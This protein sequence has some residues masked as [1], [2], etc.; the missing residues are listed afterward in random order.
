MLAVMDDQS[1]VCMALVME[2]CDQ[3]AL[4]SAVVKGCFLQ[5]PAAY[6]SSNSSSGSG[7][8]PVRNMHFI[9]LTLVE[10]ALA[11]RYLHDHNIAHLD[12]KPGNILLK[13]TK[14]NPRG[15]TAKLA[16]FGLAKILVPGKGPGGAPGVELDD[17]VGTI[18]FMAP[19]VFI[20]GE[21]CAWTRPQ[22]T[23]SSFI[24]VTGC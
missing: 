2:L 17:A 22:V 20:Q 13:S 18:H 19:E 14:S 8:A 9:Y 10:I 3:G 5:H 15:F 11:L 7:R 1:D 16:D 12:I 4:D 24:R 21:F 23:S 6:H